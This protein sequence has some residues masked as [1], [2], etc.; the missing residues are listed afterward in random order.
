MVVAI[1]NIEGR[2]GREKV[3]EEA[4]WVKRPGD[5]LH[6]ADLWAKRPCCTH[7]AKLGDLSFAHGSAANVPGQ[8]LEPKTDDAKD[9]P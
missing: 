5:R 6:I 7:V 8:S 3:I 4:V 1:H 2:A 9:H